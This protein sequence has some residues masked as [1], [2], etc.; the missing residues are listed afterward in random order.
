MKKTVYEEIVVAIVEQIDR[1]IG[2]VAI[3][4]ANTIKGL[5]VTALGDVD[6]KGNPVD[7]I[8]QL[9]KA[10]EVLIGPVAITIAKK[11]VQK[12]LEKNPNL[13]IP[14]VLK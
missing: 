10:Y 1:V 11:G 5:K 14:I 12:I 4:Q 6:I 8:K 7:K 9:I 13:K 3:V 2:P